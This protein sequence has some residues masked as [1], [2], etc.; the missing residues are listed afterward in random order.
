[1]LMNHTHAA[2]YTVK[3]DNAAGDKIVDKC[4]FSIQRQFTAYDMQLSQLLVTDSSRKS[5]TA[6]D[7][8]AKTS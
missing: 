7:Q 3:T 8:N 5:Q 4:S 6:I 1:M 2:R